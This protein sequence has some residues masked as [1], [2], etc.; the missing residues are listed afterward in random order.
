M[1][2]S[3]KSHIGAGGVGGSSAVL[4]FCYASQAADSLQLI[5]A[6]CHVLGNLRRATGGD[7]AG[8]KL[9]LA[10]P[11]KSSSAVCDCPVGQF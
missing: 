2:S 8:W 3:N 9:A 7:Q 5:I 6:S 11:M 4:S 10:N 1:S